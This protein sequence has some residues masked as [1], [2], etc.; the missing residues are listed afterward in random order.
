MTTAVLERAA[1]VDAL[2]EGVAAARAGHGGVVLVEGEAGIGKSSL[3]RAFLAALDRS[4]RTLVGGCDDLRTRRPLGPLRDATVDS[5]GPLAAAIR[6]GRPERVFAAA[7]AEL[8]RPPVT[9]LAVEDVHWADDA[10][11]DLLR[12]LA[13]RIGD[14]HGLLVLTLRPGD[15]E[16]GHP[17]R[18]LLGELAG[19]RRLRPQPLSPAAVAEL[20]GDP[21]RAAEV[22]ALTGGNPFFVTE[23]LAAPPDQVPRTVGDAVVARLGQL[24]EPARAAL[25]QLSV[26]PT[27]VGFELVEALLPGRVE[28]LEEAERRG[29][30]QVRATG[31]AF[32]HELARRAV[33][34][35]LP[36]LRRRRLNAAVLSALLAHPR[37]D[38]DRVVHH[39]VEADDADAVATHAPPAGRAA[40]RLGAHRQALAHAETA[41]RHA[42]R[43]AAAQHARLLDDYAWE[44]YNARRFDEAVLAAR[45]AVRRYEELGDHRALGAALVRCSRHLYMAGDTPEAQLAGAR[46]VQ[47]LDG[48]PDEL[49]YALAQH[50]ALLALTEQPEAAV[51]ELDQARAAATG[52]RRAEI[53]ATCL[54]YLG[55]ARC[56]RDG[57][58]GLE[59][60]RASLTHARESGLHEWIARG[61]TNL[62]E[63]LYRFGRYDE[64][65]AL[66][67]D[68]L[69]FTAEHGF[70]SHAY[71]L[72]VHHA[73][74]RLR[75][76]DWAA[77]DELRALAA[78][79][80]SAG[81]LAVYSEPPYARML[82]RR[83][84]TAAGPMLTRSWE[85]ALHQRSL[86][87]LALTGTAIAEWAFLTGQPERAEPVVAELL[88]R[89][90]RPGAVPVLAEVLRYLARAGVAVPELPDCPEPW[91][92]GLRGDW[93][94]AAAGWAQI[95][96]PYEQA[97]ELAG[98][99]APKPTLQA[100]RLLDELGATAA[101]ALVRARLRELG[102]SRMPRG[103]H[104]TTRANPAGLTSRQ[105]EVLA[106]LADGHTNADI[107]ARLVL[108][109][110]TVDH[111]VATIFDK[112]DVSTRRAAAR[113]AAE[114]GLARPPDAG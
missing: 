89:R 5:A 85:R 13:R 8:D 105:L 9:V 93:A 25:E 58:A 103:P 55:V 17:L 42:D 1:L 14:R 28:V 92:S 91:A 20:A 64:L 26:V 114:L 78:E 97:L 46:A 68:G 110:R 19:A 75:R 99:G 12:H 81:M 77:E 108:S 102:V 63:P 87:G 98:S 59:P 67:P 35:S 107:A 39:A 43:L 44:L 83:G 88:T 40:A 73:L 2:L 66:L 15:L 22:H 54:N 82:A 6:T 60:L 21:D 94:A 62:A 52:P 27:L 7:V 69:A 50:G 37:P 56:D 32:R 31:V 4:V 61:Y 71:G 51:A 90:H 104:A 11:L 30:L 53:D 100:V 79:A 96:D 57:A 29:M 74:L 33:E 48:E 65:A 113:R 95:G 101:A 34:A 18:T 24:T 36:V 45:D 47:V 49:P 23:A 70:W 86:H 84:S 10:T 72:R 106:L 109:V 112:L 111:H 41:L 3:L 76:G 80:G 38:L 16:P